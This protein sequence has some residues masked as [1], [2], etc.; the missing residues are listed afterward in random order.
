LLF[1]GVIFTV[2][3]IGGGTVGGAVGGTAL[4][5]DLLP[6]VNIKLLIRK[7]RVL[8]QYKVE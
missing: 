1:A 5:V 2:G 7:H 3:G 8:V 4:S 6:T